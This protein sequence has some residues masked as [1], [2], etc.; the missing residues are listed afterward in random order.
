MVIT[1]NLLVMTKSELLDHL[2]VTQAEL[3]RRL[4]IKPSAVAQWP[5]DEEIPLARMLQIKYE[6][7]PEKFQPAPAEA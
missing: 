5:N 4:D 7:F 1:L 2:S 3:A 6:L